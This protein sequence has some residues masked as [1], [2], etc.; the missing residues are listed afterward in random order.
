MATSS[1]ARK[2]ILRNFLFTRQIAV[3]CLVCGL[4]IFF[5]LNRSTPASHV[6]HIVAN[7]TARQLPRKH[8]RRQSSHSN[9]PNNAVF[10]QQS[11]QG[12]RIRMACLLRSNIYLHIPSNRVPA[13]THPEATSPARKPR[14]DENTAAV[15][16]NHA[17]SA[18]CTRGGQRYPSAYPHRII[19]FQKRRH[20]L[21][22]RRPRRQHHSH[23]PGARRRGQAPAPRPARPSLPALPIAAPR[24]R[25]ADAL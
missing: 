12:L 7:A 16:S 3:V 25:Y 1:G 15:T 17:A 5:S 23:S 14:S 6:A 10:S 8:W 19:H 4:F 21:L 13:S 24:R 11:K 9:E 22:Q 2:E 18:R 20:P